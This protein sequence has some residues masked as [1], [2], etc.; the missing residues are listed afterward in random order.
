MYSRSGVFP[1]SWK[2]ARVTTVFKNKGSAADPSFY[3]T[4]SVMPTL[5]WLFK[6][7]IDSQLYI[8]LLAL[9]YLKVSSY[10]FVKSTGHRIVV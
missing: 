6:C 4:V 5:E 1:L 7:I 8:T 2:V 3:H 10:G 9:V